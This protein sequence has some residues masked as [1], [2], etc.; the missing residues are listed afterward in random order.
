MGGKITNN[1]RKG[2]KYNGM[3]IFHATP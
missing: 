3:V 2:E 1:Q